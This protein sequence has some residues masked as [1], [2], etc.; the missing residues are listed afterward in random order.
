M[1]GRK[2]NFQPRAVMRVGR[3][4]ALFGFVLL[5][6]LLLL[7]RLV[8]LQIIRGS[9]YAEL[10][11][12]Q[13]IVRVPVASQRGRIVDRSG[14][15]LAVDLP[16]SYSLRVFPARL[17][18]G[19][20]L[21][22][23]LAA[24]TERPTWHYLKRMQSRTL[25]YYLEW[26]LTEE[27]KNRLEADHI[28]GILLERNTGRVYPYDHATAQL[29]GY[30]DING[31]GIS[32]LEMLC[33]SILQ[34]SQGWEMR[35][36]SANGQT[37]LDPF[38]RSEL[39]KDG[40]AVRLSIDI[41]AQVMLYQELEAAACSTGSEWLGGILLDPRTG[42]LLSIV[43]VPSYDPMRPESGDQANHKLRPLTDLI[44][45]GSVFKI[46]TATA[47]LD[48]HEVHP[49][50]V[51][52]CEAGRWTIGS[53]VL[54]D[55]HPY[56]S[57]SFEDI[58]VHS[59]NIGTAKVAARIGAREVYRYAMRFG[60][61]S[62]TGIEFPG[63][64]SG[65]L[66][67][68]DQW[69]EI[70]RANIAIGQGVS[71]TM[72]QLALAYAAIANDGILMEPRL[73]LGWTTSDRKYYP[74][75]PREVRRVMEP[76]T[77]RKMQQILAQAVERGTGKEA[78]LDSV[79]VAGKTGTAQ[80]PNLES[81]GYYQ[82]RY[83]ASFIGF[84]PAFNAERVLIICA[85]NPKG[86]YYGAQVAAPV[87][88]RVLERLLPVDA[89]RDSWQRAN[90]DF[91]EMPARFDSADKTTAPDSFVIG[92]VT[93]MP[94]L[95]ISRTAPAS[96]VPHETAGNGV[97]DLTGLTLRKALRLLADHGIPGVPVGSGRVVSQSLTPGSPV[98][99]NSICYITAELDTEGDS[100]RADSL[101]S[102]QHQAGIE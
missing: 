57:L 54:G 28:D 13:Q 61:G 29:L 88:R 71:V 95:N 16:Q 97:P 99:K 65:V 91:V 86:A 45:P 96:T 64:A 84:M 60:F 25:P 34:G 31:R 42:E 5:F 20:F 35:L 80:I 26:R 90:V 56:A 89:V 27:Q 38:N 51:F 23:E 33:D 85:Y 50:D 21:C 17:R 100:L 66:R 63:E 48:R 15:E 78:A 83:V 37:I 22:Q 101:I 47:A 87:F 69:K 102:R 12:Q 39:P 49:S 77:A 3:L 94:L 24:M 40:A 72:L 62:L 36:K 92:D 43:S 67:P 1:A 52:Y 44:E 58:M 11:R 7:V 98:L 55:A 18:Q 41:V 10:A 53:K 2:S 79:A 30:T 93:N 8:Y 68:Y 6:V 81:G 14:Q 46:V 4:Q 19:N 32:G 82:D 70:G 59:S 74:N 9:H 75:P 76:E 73:I